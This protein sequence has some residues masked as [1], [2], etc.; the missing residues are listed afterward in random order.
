MNT[1]ILNAFLADQRKAKRLVSDKLRT[2]EDI[3]ALDW[4]TRYAEL[5]KAYDACPF[6]DVFRIHGYGLEI[7][8]GDLYIDYDYSENSLADGFD[9]WRI[10]VYIMTGRFDNRGS[11]KHI[12]DRVDN[13][14]DELIKHGRIEKLDNLY[15]LANQPRK[16]AEHCGEREPP[17]T[18]DLNSY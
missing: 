3:R 9:S 12:S 7:Q 1:S 6:A 16:S 14:F 11:D 13:W 17:I 2:P 8:V 18:R 15:Y 10:F 4:A 5:R